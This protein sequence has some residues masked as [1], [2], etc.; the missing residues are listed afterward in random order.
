MT[1][2]VLQS[3]FQKRKFNASDN[4][5]MMRYKQFVKTGKWG[6]SGCPYLLEWPWLN[7]PAM[8]SHKISEHTMEQL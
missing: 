4:Q 7:I 3:K 5:D 8:I 2:S 6:D 1:S